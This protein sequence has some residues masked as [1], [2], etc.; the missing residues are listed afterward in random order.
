LFDYGPH[1]VAMS[2]QIFRR[3][4]QRVSAEIFNRKS[5]QQFCLRAELDFGPAGQAQLA[6]GNAF[7]SKQRWFRL[8]DGEND[9]LYDDLCETKL[10]RNGEAVAADASAGTPLA[11]ALES[12]A[13]HA[14]VLSNAESTWL[15]ENVAAVLGELDAAAGAAG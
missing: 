3:R 15:S 1:D 9:W 6:F 10:R 8:S 14:V 12:F 2:L 11:T 13:G 7:E 4:P 5:R